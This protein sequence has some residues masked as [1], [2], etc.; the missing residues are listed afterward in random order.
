MSG[1]SR[2]R[3][4]CRSPSRST[5]A[6]ARPAQAVLVLPEPRDG[7]GVRAPRSW[8]RSSRRYSSRYSVLDASPPRRSRAPPQLDPRAG[9]RTSRLRCGTRAREQAAPGT[10]R[11]RQ[12]RDAPRPPK[13]FHHT[14]ARTCRT[15]SSRPSPVGSTLLAAA[16]RARARVRRSGR[17]R[18]TTPQR[19]PRR[20][21]KPRTRVGTQMAQALASS[22]QRP[23]RPTSQGPPRRGS[24]TARLAGAPARARLR[25]RVLGCRASASAVR[26]RSRPPAARRRRRRRDLNSSARARRSGRSSC[27]PTRMFP[28]LCAARRRT[29][30]SAWSDGGGACLRANLPTTRTT[31]RGAAPARAEAA[32]RAAT[33]LRAE[34][35][36]DG[37]GCG[38]RTTQGR[39]AHAHSKRKPAG[40][41]RAALVR[42]RFAARP[43]RR[44]TSRFRSAE[45]R[46]AAAAGLRRFAR[47]PRGVLQR[48]GGGGPSC[49]R[50]AHPSPA[51]AGAWLEKRRDKGVAGAT[52]R[53]ADSCRAPGRERRRPSTPGRRR[54][55]LDV[56]DDA[57]RVRVLGARCPTPLA[58]G[59]SPGRRRTP[60]CFAR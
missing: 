50:A 56:F 43:A 49:S 32:R 34:R 45:R 14:V 23:H 39:S 53:L 30:F 7:E 4:K 54:S 46:R 2:A 8:R 52:A 41:S 5:A 44:G 25:A 18:R 24:L 15:R 10:R 1:K 29:R 57:P 9:W 55:V 35:G 38:G 33:A 6:S 3:S 12:R 20:S 16:P 31:R 11:R 36:G 42:P 17:P 26:L 60:R 27:A 13:R 21:A 22:Q 19:G 47:P 51:A 40:G 48:G 28:A 37:A 59:G 58:R